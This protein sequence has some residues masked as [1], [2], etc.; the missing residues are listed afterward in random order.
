MKGKLFFRLITLIAA[1]NF[2]SSLAI[3]A[4]HAGIKLELIQV[5]RDN[6]NGV[7]GLDNPRAV[8]IS[9]DGKTLLVA[10]GDDNALAVFKV[11]PNFSVSYQY[12]FRNDDP[13]ISGLEG[14][15]QVVFAAESVYVASFYNGALAVFTKKEEAYQFSMS[16]SDGL[17]PELVFKSKQPLQELDKLGLLGAWDLVSADDGKTLYVSA[18]KSNLISRFEVTLQGKTTLRNK[19]YGSEKLER[20]LGGPVSIIISPD[21]RSMIVAG[22][23][24]NRLTIFSISSE[25]ELSIEQVIDKEADNV[26][27]LI[28]PQKLTM[29]PDGQFLY[30]ACSGSSS[31]LVFQKQTNHRFKLLQSIK[32]KDLLEVSIQGAGSL[33]VSPDGILVFI[34]G[35]AGSGLAILQRQEDGHLKQI[36][37][38]LTPS[39]NPEV[40]SGISSLNVA[41]NGKYLLATSAKNDALL[42][43]SL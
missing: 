7:D 30:V 42:V 31:L 19:Y 4:K 8:K 33:A 32:N 12:S 36:Q 20:G 26:K 39:A 5:V 38:S 9:P 43:F 37:M 16:I 34:A 35:E 14:A 17:S 11:Y 40:L 10:S 27:V 24:N 3:D 41:G 1:L 15:S 18:Y 2:N 29:S 22:F 23:D 28:N 6:E 25:G 13:E 21:N